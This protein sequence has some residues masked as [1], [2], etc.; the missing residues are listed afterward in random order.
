[1]RSRAALRAMPEHEF[2]PDSISVA[3][4]GHLDAA[5]LSSHAQVRDSYLLALARSHGGR[6]ATSTGAWLSTRCSRGGGSSSR[7]DCARG[8]AWR[9]IWLI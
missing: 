7:S 3:D 6:L 1:V 8:A 4:P 9:E 5:R 2:W